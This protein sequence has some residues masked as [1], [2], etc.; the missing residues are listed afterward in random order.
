MRGNALATVFSARREVCRSPPV[1]G[2]K[3]NTASERHGR[4]ENL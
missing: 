4:G 3:I 2:I 1:G